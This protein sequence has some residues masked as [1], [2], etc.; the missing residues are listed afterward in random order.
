MPAFITVWVK[1]GA[2]RVKFLAQE[3]NGV[4]RT[5]KQLD[6]CASQDHQYN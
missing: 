6:H 5:I 3:H 4:Q 2:V 1:R